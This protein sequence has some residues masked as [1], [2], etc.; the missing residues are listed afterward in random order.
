M[1]E[2]DTTRAA[3][4]AGK[5]VGVLNGG[6]LALM[7]TIGHRTGLFRVLVEPM[8]GKP[9]WPDDHFTR[10][11]SRVRGWIQMETVSVGYELWRQLNDFPLEFQRPVET[12]PRKG[13]GKGLADKEASKKAK[14]AKDDAKDGGEEDK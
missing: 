3:V 11:G 13:A 2:Y 5:M 9:A 8:P 12:G 6:M 10:L 7:L 1:T 4:F 14:P